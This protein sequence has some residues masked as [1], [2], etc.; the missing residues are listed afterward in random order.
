MSAL[1]VAAIVLA[2]G[3]GSRMGGP[4]KLLATFDG[5]PS[6]ARVVRAALASRAVSVTVVTGNRAGEVEAAL[7]GLPVEI[8]CNPDYALGL[9]TS[10]QTGLRTLSTDIDAMLV[11][12]GDMP[13]VTT[14]MI[15]EIIVKAM[16]LTTMTIVVPVHD[17]QRGN[18]VLWR[19]A[20]FEELM[21][22]TGDKGGRDVMRAHPQAVAEIPAGREV[23]VDI[24]TPETLA[25]EGGRLP[26][27]WHS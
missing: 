21:A 7:A 1:R 22:V 16:S 15:D 18:P 9:S 6:V 26:T 4:N 13:L 10:L 23:A 24:D 3:Q 27:N 11:L 8:V 12:L 17:G 25:E 20:H 2:A 5:V 14:A 19:R